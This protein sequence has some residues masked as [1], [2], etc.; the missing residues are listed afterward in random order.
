MRANNW[1]RIHPVESCVLKVTPGRRPT[2]TTN[3]LA[4]SGL[5]RSFS[6]DAKSY[7]M[8][9]YDPLNAVETRDLVG[10]L[11]TTV[12]TSLKSGLHQLGLKVYIFFKL[13]R[14]D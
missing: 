13:E 9:A 10:F 12:Y 8:S 7:L 1:T 6:K 14:M 3:R 4:N 11:A 2:K 5:W